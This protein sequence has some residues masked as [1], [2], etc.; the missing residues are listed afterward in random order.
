[1]AQGDSFRLTAGSELGH[2][3]QAQAQ[4]QWALPHLPGEM[5]K[6][7]FNSGLCKFTQEPQSELTSSWRPPQ[8]D[9][10][11]APFADVSFSPSP[12]LRIQGGRKAP[13]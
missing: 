4:H 1:M 6:G 11:M 3:G 13:P 12:S 2:L 8:T 5:G 9:P 10:N 7:S